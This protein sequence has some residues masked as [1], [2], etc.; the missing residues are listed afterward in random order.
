[1][2]SFFDKS[3]RITWSSCTKETQECSDLVQKKTRDVGLFY[4]RVWLCYKRAQEM[5]DSSAKEPQ[6]FRLFCKRDTGM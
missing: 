2:W 3:N 5:L 1:M 6:K 4:K